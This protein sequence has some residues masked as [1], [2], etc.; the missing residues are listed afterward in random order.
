MLD[1]HTIF[2][3]RLF[4]VRIIQIV[5]VRSIVFN[6]LKKEHLLFQLSPGNRPSNSIMLQKMTPFILGALIG[7]YLLHSGSLHLVM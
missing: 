3:D 6:M 5:R 1:R 2:Y 7:K 4:T